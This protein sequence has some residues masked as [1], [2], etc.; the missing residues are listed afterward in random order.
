[1]RLR[2]FVEGGHV[3]DHARQVVR[4]RG[5][6]LNFECLVEA[7]QSLIQ[8][9][10]SAI[11]ILGRGRQGLLNEQ[12]RDIDHWRHGS[13]IQPGGFA[14]LSFGVRVLIR[15][16]EENRQT[17]VRIEEIRLDSDRSFQMILAAARF[18]FRPSAIPF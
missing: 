2:L 3:I 8:S 6:G 12:A 1:M 10:S 4:Q 18:P 14:I 11:L 17:V 16:M 15:A 7:C 9:N 5:A 13:R